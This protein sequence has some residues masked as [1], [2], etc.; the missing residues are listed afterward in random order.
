[1]EQTRKFGY[2]ELLTAREYNVAIGLYLFF[3]ILLT[4]IV[5]YGAGDVT[6]GLMNIHPLAFAII[7]LAVMLGCN[8]IVAVT[9]SGIFATG[10]Y[11]VMCTMTGLLLSTY[12]PEYATDVVVRAFF[13]TVAI[14]GIMLATAVAVPSVFESMGKTLFICLVSTI[15][16]ELVSMLIGVNTGIYDWIVVGIFSLYIGF[17]WVK[18][19]QYDATLQGAVV[20]SIEL[21]MDLVNI[22]VRLLSIMAKS[23]KNN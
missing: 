21:Y 5:T 17:D 9:T 14:L 23:K 8:A 10:F 2:T 20:T 18:G 12:V 7:Y 6:S 3:G 19:Q 1:M 13:S 11:L 16:V 15:V 22:F 4:G